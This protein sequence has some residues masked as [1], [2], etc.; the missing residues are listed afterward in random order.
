MYVHVPCSLKIELWRWCRSWVHSL[1]WRICPTCECVCV[2][3]MGERGWGKSITIAT[4]PLTFLPV[5]N[6]SSC[7]L[8][9]DAWLTF[10]TRKEEEIN[11]LF[12]VRSVI[13]GKDHFDHIACQWDWLWFK[14]SLSESRFVLEAAKWCHAFEDVRVNVRARVNCV[15]LKWQSNSISDKSW[16]V[17]K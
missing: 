14:K 6:R 5:T 9:L 3:V 4:W 2:C 10:F 1:S 17:S 7:C 11:N 15:Y 13:I 16:Q 12:F 8:V